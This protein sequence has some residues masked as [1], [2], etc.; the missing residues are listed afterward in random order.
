MGLLVERG[1]KIAAAAA[2][3]ATAAAAASEW[4]VSYC[5]KT[6]RAA[7][8]ARACWLALAHVQMIYVLFNTMHN[9]VGKDGRITFI[10]LK[11]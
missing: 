4:N 9:K 1:W 6:F 5:I 8:A 2:A 7:V 3:A 10:L 11:G